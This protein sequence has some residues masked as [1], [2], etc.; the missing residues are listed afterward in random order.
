MPGDRVRLADGKGAVG[1]FDGVTSDG[2]AVVYWGT[3]DGD[4]KVTEVAPVDLRK[5]DHG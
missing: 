3:T 2:R 1:V 5:V 4:K